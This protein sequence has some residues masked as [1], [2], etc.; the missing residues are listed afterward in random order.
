MDIQALARRGGGN[1]PRRGRHLD[2]SRDAD[3]LRAALGLLAEIGY[4]RLTME[5]VA[6]RAQAGKATLYRRWPSKAELVVDAVLAFDCDVE[7]LSVDTGSLRGD[8]ATAFLG[9]LADVSE[10]EI[11]LMSGMMTALRRH[12]H[13]ATI[14]EE[15]FTARKLAAI[16]TLFERARDRG[17]V[18]DGHDIELLA[19]IGPGIVFHR[20]LLTGKPLTE[21][22]ILRVIDEV[23]LPLAGTPIFRKATP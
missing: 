6:A 14:F 15:R 12:P 19:E 1:C 5:A 2:E 11:D 3:I 13:L 4:D 16:R 21:E 17:E 22:F 20:L 7:H 18:A 9:V 23:I 10:F 8:L